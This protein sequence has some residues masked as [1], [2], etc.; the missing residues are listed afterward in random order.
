VFLFERPNGSPEFGWKEEEKQIPTY[1]AELP[2][3]PSSWFPAN[4]SGKYA[5]FWESKEAYKTFCRKWNIEAE[6]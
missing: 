5:T 3:L 2:E 1:S 6:N 4:V